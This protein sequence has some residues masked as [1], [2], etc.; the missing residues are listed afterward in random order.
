M[1]KAIDKDMY[2]VNKISKRKFDRKRTVTRKNK[3]F[4]CQRCGKSHEPKECPAWQKTCSSCGKMTHF[5]LTLK[6]LRCFLKP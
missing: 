6:I 5:Q 4:N 2:S 3:N 1:E